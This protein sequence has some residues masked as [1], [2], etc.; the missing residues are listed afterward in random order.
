[1]GTNKLPVRYDS[2]GRGERVMIR[3][4][5][6]FGFNDQSWDKASM[7]NVVWVLMN[8]CIEH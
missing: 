1:M 8:R 2:R 5:P 6:A 3:G 7:R 4:S